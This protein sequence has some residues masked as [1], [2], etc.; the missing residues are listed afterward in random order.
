KQFMCGIC[1]FFYFDDAPVNEGVIRDMDGVLRHQGTDEG[2]VHIG[3]R[4]ALGHRIVSIIPL[5]SDPHPL[6]TNDLTVYLGF[7]SKIY[8]YLELQRQLK[9]GHTCRTR[10]D[11]E[12]IVHL[13]ETYPI[14]FVEKLR[15]MFAFALWDERKRTM[16]LARDRV[17]KKP[18]YYYLDHQKLVFGSEIKAI[19][20]HPGLALDIDER[21]VSDYVSLGYIPSPKSIY[22]SIRKVRPGHYLRVT[23]DTVEEIPY[24]DLR[25]DE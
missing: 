21:A 4:A 25:F 1:G 8:N 3:S 11:T 5:S 12:T 22:R 18:L 24:W 14:T 10:S 2:G 20:R 13:Y 23:P 17:G 6:S 9:D 19:L 16:T 7:N 15:G